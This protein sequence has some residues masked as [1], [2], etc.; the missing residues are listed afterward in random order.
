MINLEESI[1]NMTFLSVKVFVPVLAVQ[2]ARGSLLSLS[3]AF[4]C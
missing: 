1:L 2:R 3:Y 4:E